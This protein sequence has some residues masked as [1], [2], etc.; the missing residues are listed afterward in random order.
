MKTIFLSVL[1]VWGCTSNDHILELECTQNQGAACNKLAQKKEG[2]EAEALYKRSCE[3]G[4]ANGCVN[5]AALV[6]TKDSAGALTALQK[7]CD[8]GD[9]KAC[10]DRA[11]L[12]TGSQPPTKQ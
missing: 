6:K 7:A 12:T 8:Q 11:A 5:Y 2:D 10:A 9:A 4:H 3:L 1:L